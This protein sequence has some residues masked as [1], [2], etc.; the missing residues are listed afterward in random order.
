[1]S[2]NTKATELATDIESLLRGIATSAGKQ[3]EA[4]AASLRQYIA[5]QM[6]MLSAAT[7]Q[8]GFEEALEASKDSV[9]L[10]AGILAVNSADATDAAIVSVIVAGLTTGARALA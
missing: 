4:D 7:G 3:I 10:R 2:D 6:I 1:M 9:L 8:P 5:E